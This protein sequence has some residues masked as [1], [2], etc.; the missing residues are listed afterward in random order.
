MYSIRQGSNLVLCMWMSS[1]FST[2]YWKDSSFPNELSRHPYQKSIDHKGKVFFSWT[3]NCIPLTSMSIFMPVAHNCD[4]CS[5]GL[6]FEIG[7]VNPLT[8]FFFFKDCFGSFWSLSFYMDFRISA[9]ISAKYPAGVL[10]GTA[11]NLQISRPGFVWL[12]WA[13]KWHL[14]NLLFLVFFQTV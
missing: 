5:F 12:I 14:T 4:Y 8:L 2:I 11:L 10:I 7:S 1:C 13:P 9:S 3:L 6:S